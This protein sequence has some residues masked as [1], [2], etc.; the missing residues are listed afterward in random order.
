MT[1]LKKKAG[2]RRAEILACARLL[3]V[4]EGARALTL[5][6]VANQVGLKLASVQYYFPTHSALVTALVEDR[7]AQQQA[8]IHRLREATGGDAQRVLKAVLRMWT[9][10]SE[11]TLEE[12]RLDVQFW[13]LA[14]IDATAKHALNRYQSLYIDFLTGLI[15]EALG[16]TKRRAL[17]RAVSIASLVEGSVLFVDLADQS[18]SGHNHAKDI[19]D[20][21]RLIAFAEA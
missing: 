1:T 9:T 4:R 18:V 21:A 19:F 13:A 20:A 16:L 5:R 6:G 7:L 10:E 15:Q 17:A 3:L 11:Q 12:S 8:D 14:E 2:E